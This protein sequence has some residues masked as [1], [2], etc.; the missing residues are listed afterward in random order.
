MGEISRE[1]LEEE[2][3]VYKYR[4]ED[5]MEAGNLAWWEMELPSGEVRFNDRKAKMLGYSPDKFDHYEDF[6]DLLHPD[7]HDKAMQAM[8]DHL[9]GDA[10]RYEVEYRIKKKDGDYKWYRDVGSITEEDENGE[11]KKV[12]GIVIDIDERKKTEKREDFLHSLLR[13]DVGNKIQIVQGYLQL[14]EDFELPAELE[15]YLSE[16]K[17]AIETAQEIIEKIEMLRKVVSEEETH[18]VEICSTLESVIS[19]YRDIFKKH[20]IGLKCQDEKIKVLGGPLLKEM[21]SNILENNIKHANCDKVQISTEERDEDVLIKV[22]DDG[23]GI[24]DDIKEDLF[25]R[26][27]KKG[28]SGGSGLG[29]YLV[30]EI[31][32]IYGGNIEVKDSTMGGAKFII[33]L[34]KA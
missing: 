12:T 22:E 11:Y 4:L 10:E 1:E 24:P 15:E 29:L 28:E 26:G 31:A 18:T 3:E 27:F 23:K 6:T 17:K 33:Y 2:L 5:A 13:H 7:D 21:F 9:E 34:K 8:R 19:E 30:K 25:K 20:D 32:E 16:G 14:A